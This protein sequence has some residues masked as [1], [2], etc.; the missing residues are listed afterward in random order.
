MGWSIVVPYTSIENWLK[1]IAGHY[2]ASKLIAAEWL[3]SLLCGESYQSV[4][5]CIWM[6][7]HV[8]IQIF[9]PSFWPWILLHKTINGAYGSLEELMISYLYLIWIE[10]YRGFC[11]LANLII[12]TLNVRCKRNSVDIFWQIFTVQIVL[13]IQIIWYICIHSVHIFL[14]VKWLKFL[15]HIWICK[16][17]EKRCCNSLYIVWDVTTAILGNVALLP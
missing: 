2:A 15:Y 8:L 14:I 9:V 10:Q 3:I 6:K 5:M 4:V 17:I 1:N 7:V 11:E 12:A 13:H 16:R